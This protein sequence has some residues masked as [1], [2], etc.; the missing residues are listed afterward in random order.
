MESRI[1][2]ASKFDV[3]LTIFTEG[4][5][6]MKLIPGPLLPHAVNLYHTSAV[7]GKE[8]YVFTKRSPAALPL[9]MNIGVVCVHY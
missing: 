9:S 4:S 1:S 7:N 8:I 5:R 6:Y 3:D 2:I